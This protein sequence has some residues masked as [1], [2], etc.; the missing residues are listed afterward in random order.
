M[1]K[2]KATLNKRTAFLFTHALDKSSR[3]QKRCSWACKVETD[4][5]KRAVNNYAFCMMDSVS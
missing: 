1:V 2:I 4:I 3:S 5:C